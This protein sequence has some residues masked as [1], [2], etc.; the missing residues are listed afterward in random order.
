MDQT[1]KQNQQ[2]VFIDSDAKTYRDSQRLWITTFNHCFGVTK[3]IAELID[4]PEPDIGEIGTLEQYEQYWAYHDQFGKSPL[5]KNTWFTPGTPEGVCKA[6]DRARV[7][8]LRIRV[9]LGD[10]ETGEDWLIAE[11][12]IGYVGRKDADEVFRRPLFLR[13]RLS[14]KGPELRTQEI[15]RI[16]AIKDKKELYRHPQ[17]HMPKLTPGKDDLKGAAFFYKDEGGEI[18]TRFPTATARGNW[19]EFMLGNRFRLK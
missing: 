18:V 16:M 19:C 13:S 8:G 7:E 14:K 9:W 10:Q 1:D 4:L 5:S 15:I 3:R 6:L 17:Y 2:T 12:S 11:D